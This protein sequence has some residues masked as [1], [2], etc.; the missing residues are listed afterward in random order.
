MQA[1]AWGSG[2][3]GELGL[4]ISTLDVVH[5]TQIRTKHKY[6]QVHCGWQH[7]LFVSVD[8]KVMSTTQI[9]RRKQFKLLIQVSSC[10]SNKHGQLGTKANSSAFYS[11]QSV[12]T[13]EANGVKEVLTIKQI[14]VGWHHCV[15]ITLENEVLS[16]GKGSHGQLGNLRYDLRHTFVI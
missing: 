7:S 13:T 6:R 8:G 10:G 5:P 15:C 9:N 11:P 2:R 3:H 12:T 1:F 16:W 4:G 14:S